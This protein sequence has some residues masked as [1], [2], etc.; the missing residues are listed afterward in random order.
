MNQFFAFLYAWNAGSLLCLLGFAK[1]AA[2]PSPV[3]RRF[4][5]LGG[6][7]V[8]TGLMYLGTWWP[9]LFTLLAI[10][11][12]PA[13][14]FLLVAAFLP[15]VLNSIGWRRYAFISQVFG[16]MALLYWTLALHLNSSG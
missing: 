1:F 9:T 8:V 2:G 4:A 16:E 14:V 10:V 6:L 15:R 3:A 12:V 13:W 7:L 5:S 11:S